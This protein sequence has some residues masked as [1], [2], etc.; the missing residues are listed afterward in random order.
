M[1]HTMVATINSSLPSPHRDNKDQHQVLTIHRGNPEVK[2][3]ILDEEFILANG[4]EMFVV[5]RYQ[6]I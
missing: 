5:V 4:I 2:E 6:T 1:S 3:I